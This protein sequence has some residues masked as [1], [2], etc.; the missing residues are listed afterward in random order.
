MEVRCTWISLSSATRS[1]NFMPWMTD[2]SLFAQKRLQFCQGVIREK[3]T[4]TY[5]F[6]AGATF[7]VFSF[8][9]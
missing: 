3:E 9:P 7:M 6:I 8:F 2:M 1:M 4:V 5:S